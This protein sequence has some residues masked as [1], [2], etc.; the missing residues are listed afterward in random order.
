[1]ALTMLKPRL[2]PVGSKIKSGNGWRA[3]KTTGE[4]GYDYRW[5]KARDRYLRMHPLCVYCE[6]EGRRIGA[7]SVVDHKTP[8]RGDQVLFWDESNW[9]PL[10][11][12]H[13]DVDKAREERGRG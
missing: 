5:Q 3:G 4:R 1:M 8:H 2:Q 9:Q 12:P 11:K 13:H 6:R 7:A 10:C